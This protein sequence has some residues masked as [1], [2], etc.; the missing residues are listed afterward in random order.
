MESAVPGNVITYGRIY[1]LTVTTVNIDGAMRIP[2][3]E[4]N[5]PGIIYAVAVGRECTGNKRGI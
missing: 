5:I 2:A 4:A 1:L 3:Q